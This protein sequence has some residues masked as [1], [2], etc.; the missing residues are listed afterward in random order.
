[1]F[2]SSVTFILCLY[3]FVTLFCVYIY[4]WMYYISKKNFETEDYFFVTQ[5]SLLIV[6][7]LV[8]TIKFHE[9]M[10]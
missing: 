9:L 4:M 10:F 2:F 6:N 8:S 5:L 3:V 7:S 1:M